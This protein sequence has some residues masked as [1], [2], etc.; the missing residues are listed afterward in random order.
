MS[1][2]QVI[3]DDDPSMFV[4]RIYQLHTSIGIRTIEFNKLQFK[5]KMG[6]L[7]DLLLP[8]MFHRLNL[9]PLQ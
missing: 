7:K 2:F 8:L 1:C 9:I 5:I 6:I 3:E 4:Q